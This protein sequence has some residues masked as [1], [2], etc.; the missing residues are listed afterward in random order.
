MGKYKGALTAKN[1]AEYLDRVNATLMRFQPELHAR[2]FDEAIYITGNFICYGKDGAFDAFEIEV[3]LSV[4]FP[5]VEPFVREKGNKIPRIADRHIYPD[6]GKCCLCVWQEWLWEAQHPDFE[7]F[8]IGPLHTY[9]VSQSIFEMTG[10]WR[11]G[12][13]SHDKE[14]LDQALG[15]MLD[16]IPRV[17]LD[18]ALSLLSQSKIKGHAMCPCGSG[19]RLRSCHF[20]E[21]L[22]LKGRLSVDSW[23]E[24]RRQRNAY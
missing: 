12:E 18:R 7:T 16:V 20:D 10:E 23:R 8:L 17:Q 9:F 14:G 11:F 2:Y 22:S 13:R 6:S 19:K 3:L 1:T 21:L 5:E 4:G 24:M 15:E